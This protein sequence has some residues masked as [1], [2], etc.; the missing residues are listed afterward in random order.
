MSNPP[1][2]FEERSKRPRGNGNEYPYVIKARDLMEN[3]VFATLDIDQDLIEETTGLGGHKQRRLKIPA[4]PLGGNAILIAQPG[5]V[6]TWL[7]TPLGE[8]KP[9]LLGFHKNSFAWIKTEEC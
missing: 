2:D 5:G 6:V 1:I 3:F 9:V 7:P 8:D 4:P